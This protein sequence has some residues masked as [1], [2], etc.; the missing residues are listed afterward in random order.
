MKM[1]ICSVHTTD[2]RLMGVDPA[3]VFLKH[4]LK[5]LKLVLLSLQEHVLQGFRQWCLRDCYLSGQMRMVGKEPK[6]Q[7]LPC[8][9]LLSYP[10]LSY[11]KY[12]V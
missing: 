11:S 4:H 9:P 3:L 5:V 12:F 8:N 2:G 6:L 7:S 10:Y 1:G